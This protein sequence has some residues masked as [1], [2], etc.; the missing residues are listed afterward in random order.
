[1]KSK[2]F[3]ILK[4]AL[5]NN[6]LYSIRI[7]NGKIAE[8]TDN[9]N[10]GF[11]CKGFHVLPGLIDIHSHGFSGMDTMDANLDEIAQQLARKGTTSWLPTTMTSSSEAL[12][13]V[14]ESSLK[15]SGCNILG[16]HLEGPFISTEYKGAQNEN[17]IRVADFN[18]LKSYKNVRMITVAPEIDGNMDFVKK[19]AEAGYIVSLGHTA[20]NYETACKAFDKGASCVTHMYNAMPA[21]HHR[22]TGV[23]GA[24]FMKKQYAQ[25]ICDGLHVSKPAVLTA[26]KMLGP[27]RMI[28]ISDSIRPAGL[29][30][31]NYESGGLSVKLQNGECRLKDGNLAGSVASLLDCV[32]KAIE[33]GIPFNDAVRMASRTPAELLNINKGIVDVGYDADLILTDNNLN[34]KHVFIGGKQYI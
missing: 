34:L 28:L 16:F 22:D 4:N 18:E 20:A 27:E 2:A 26:Y 21:F 32:K 24:A 9:C 7:E 8:I 3:M 15:S 19:A 6:N 10:D 13:K 23:I 12:K 30:D 17:H 25:I 31:G 33:F 29:S 14:T 5:L 11:D 1:M